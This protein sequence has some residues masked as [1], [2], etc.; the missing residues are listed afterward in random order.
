MAVQKFR[1][2]VFVLIGMVISLFP[3]CFYTVGAQP[4]SEVASLINQLR[5]ESADVRRAAARALGQMGS[6][7]KD[8][9]PHLVELLKD[10]HAYV[11]RDA[12]RS[13]GWMHSAAKDA[14]PHLVELLEDP[15]PG[16]RKAAADALGQIGSVA[17]DAV[18]KLLELLK[19]PGGGVRWAAADAL[20][21]MGSAAKDAVPH[22]VELL[23]DP[24]EDVRMAAARALGQIGA[25]EKDVV[26]HLIELLKDPN[27]GFRWAFADALATISEG[28]SDKNKPDVVARQALQE[29][30]QILNRTGTDREVRVRIKR[31]IDHLQALERAS[32]ISQASTW[33]QTALSES[34]VI[35]A[36]IVYLS[37]LLILSAIFIVKPLWL[38]HWNEALKNQLSAKI[39][40]YKSE[41]SIGGIT[42][43]H[44]S[45]ITFMASR[46]YVLDA[47]VRSHIKKA[48][49]NFNELARFTYGLLARIIL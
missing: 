7:A 1:R 19:D 46:S 17:K 48:R 23:K 27:V 6:A 9:V 30:R 3:T 18:P 20:G 13:L 47:W 36:I 5:N 42:L 10:T 2:L 25:E 41:F 39:P 14:V 15:D 45:L 24:D 49:E 26:P 43:G 11:R 38:L 12:T 34:L 35:W 4:S 29:T 31:A 44:L 37:W 40:L 21:Q 22:L 28:L 16:V 8:A 32:I 33:F